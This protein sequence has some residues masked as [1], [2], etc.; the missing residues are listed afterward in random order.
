MLPAPSAVLCW[1]LGPGLGPSSSPACCKVCSKVQSQFWGEP[2]GRKRGHPHG[3]L[4]SR[5]GLIK[6]LLKP[7]IRLADPALKRA[8]DPRARTRLCPA[9][10]IFGNDLA[11]P[12]R[13]WQAAARS[14]H[15]G[16]TEHKPSILGNLRLRGVAHLQINGVE[17][18]GLAARRACP[19]NSPAEAS[20]PP[21]RRAGCP[22]GSGSQ[23]FTAVPSP[24]SRAQT[25]NPSGGNPRMHFW[26]SPSVLCA[27]APCLGPREIAL[28]CPSSTAHPSHANSPVASSS[29]RRPRALA[30]HRVHSTWL[31]GHLL[32]SHFI[33]FYFLFF[34]LFFFF[35]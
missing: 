12:S 26:A 4:P 3:Q 9:K 35:S 32:P 30:L 10:S 11:L 6:S 23:P 13:R 25:Q 17:G 22:G 5:L 19:S 28:P 31:P 20:Q 7:G 1:D 16:Q 14:A 27:L 24:A 18:P 29:H 21:C 2:L 8:L 15:A 33:S 34:N